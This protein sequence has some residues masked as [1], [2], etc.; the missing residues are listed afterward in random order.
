MSCNFSTTWAGVG[1]KVGGILFIVGADTFEGCAFRLDSSPKA[2]LHEVN[3]S[4]LRGGVGLGGGAGM[5]LFFAFNVGTLW[6][7]NDKKME[8]DWGVNLSIP[9][10][11]IGIGKVSVRVLKNLTRGK[12]L[13]KHFDAKRLADFRTLAS[14]FWSMM[15]DVGAGVNLSDWKAIVIDV[16]EAGWAAEISAFATWGEISIGGRVFG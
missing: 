7:I 5:S 3:V 10:E 16:P 2:S 11:K 15:F 9:G 8:P 1:V 13:L 6:E 4:S 14:M 12:D